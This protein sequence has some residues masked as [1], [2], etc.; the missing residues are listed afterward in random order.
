ME[1]L[2]Y[3]SFYL[4]SIKN[5]LFYDIIRYLIKIINKIDHFGDSSI[6]STYE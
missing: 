6:N 3:A 4:K 2:S 5:T 1:L